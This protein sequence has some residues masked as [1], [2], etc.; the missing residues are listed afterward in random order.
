MRGE[1][2][3]HKKDKIVEIFERNIDWD[4]VRETLDQ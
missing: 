1:I 2:N 3:E 4:A